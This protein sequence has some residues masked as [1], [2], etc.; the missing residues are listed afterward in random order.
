MQEQLNCSENESCV[1][2][3]LLSEDEVGGMQTALA[4]STVQYSTVQYSTVQYSRHDYMYRDWY[5]AASWSVE[6]TLLG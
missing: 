2:M 6:M 5:R 3:A 4:S 1:S